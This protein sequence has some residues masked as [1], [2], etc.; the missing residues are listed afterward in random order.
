MVVVMELMMVV[1]IVSRVYG[2]GYQRGL[3][4]SFEPVKSMLI[5]WYL[6][7]SNI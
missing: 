6:K 4:G 1:V 5:P 7:K 3:Y 2:S